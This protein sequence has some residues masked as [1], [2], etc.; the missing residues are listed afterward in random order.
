[1]GGRDST[2]RWI[3]EHETVNANQIVAIF[4]I[5]KDRKVKAHDARTDC[6]DAKVEW[7]IPYSHRQTKWLVCSQCH[8]AI[9]NSVC[10]EYRDDL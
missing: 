8:Y 10:N 2:S 7:Y 6:C 4:G 5:K 1:M 3:D 9:K